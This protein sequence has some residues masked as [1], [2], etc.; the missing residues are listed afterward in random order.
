VQLDLAG[1]TALITGGSRGIGRAVAEELAAG[2]CNCVL[3]SRNAG[4]LRTAQ[5]AIEKQYGV[6]VRT[7]ALDLADSKN[8]AALAAKYPGID[9]L[10][11]NAG[12]IPGGKLADVDEARWRAAWD[13]K[14]MGTINM[15]RAFYPLMKA[16]GGGAIVNVIGNAART[17]DPNYICGVTGNAGLTA[18]TEAMGSVSLHDN[19]RVNGVSPGPTATDRLVG[20]VSS[21]AEKEL[22]DVN[23]WRELFSSLPGGR[24]G[25]PG[26][27]AAMVAFLASPKSNFTSGAVI[28]IDAGISSRSG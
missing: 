11:N 24:P 8:V 16:R 23:R 9:I 25:D 13:L 28:T 3:V 21:R 22:G 17:R 14:V 12:A 2:G 20:L 10:I 5:E 1:K 15:T 19:I 26:E 27:I 4:D 18:F 6:S 7:E